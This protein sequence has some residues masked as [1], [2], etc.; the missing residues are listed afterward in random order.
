M[1]KTNNTTTPNLKGKR[2]VLTSVLAAI[3]QALFPGLEAV[4][5]APAAGVNEAVAIVAALVKV[6][7]LDL[8]TACAC[9][10]VHTAAILLVLR[11]R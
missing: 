9:C 6:P 3:A 4:A 10:W 11:F 5:V 1:V 7:R 8:L 2:A